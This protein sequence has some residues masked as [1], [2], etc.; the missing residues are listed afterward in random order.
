MDSGGILATKTASTA[1]AQAAATRTRPVLV[2]LWSPQ[3]DTE[4]KLKERELALLMRRLV[5]WL[6]LHPM[7]RP[8]ASRAPLR[9][10]PKPT[11]TDLNLR[12]SYSPVLR[13]GRPLAIHAGLAH[14]MCREAVGACMLRRVWL[15]SMP[16]GRKSLIL[17]PVILSPALR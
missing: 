8:H 3:P 13:T 5:A 17:R 12:R 1:A 16:S 7:G 6:L 11:F 4:A 14:Q 15:L 10:C 2:P 9:A